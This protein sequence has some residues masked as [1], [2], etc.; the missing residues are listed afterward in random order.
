[1]NKFELFMVEIAYEVAKIP[2][3]KKILSPI[4]Y[5]IKKQFA[6]RQN[7]IF[8]KNALDVIKDFNECCEINNINYTLAFGTLLGAIREKGF[9]K[10]DLDVDVAIWA[11]DYSDKIPKKLERSG[12]KL[13]HSFEV[14]KGLLGREETYVKSGVSIDIFYFY[15]GD[16]VYPY[17]CDFIMHKGATTF[18]S[19]MNR[20]GKVIPRR[21][22]LPLTKER[23]QT[24]FEGTKLYVPK[25]AHEILVF[26]YG[27]NYMIPDPDWHMELKNEHIMVWEGKSGIYKEYE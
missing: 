6:I 19:C 11:N 27:E 5:P 24:D 4:Y 12:F 26:R 23:V 2:F 16:G 22:E 14:D 21:I 13:V 9:I 8:K 15:E 3:V 20:F 17:C 7:K 25:N 18:R 1:M 10:H